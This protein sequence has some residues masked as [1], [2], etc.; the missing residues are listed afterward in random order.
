MGQLGAWLKF[1]ASSPLLTVKVKSELRSVSFI[2]VNVKKTFSFPHH[3]QCY[4]NHSWL[5][6]FGHTLFF[7]TD[8]RNDRKQRF[9]V[10]TGRIRGE[11]EGWKN[12]LVA[13]IPSCQQA[14]IN[15]AL[16]PE[17]SPDLGRSL[18]NII[19]SWK[20]ATQNLKVLGNREGVWFI[21]SFRKC[22]NM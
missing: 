1:L 7:C 8:I 11:R 19:Q 10:E 6:N 16:S 5:M 14:P 21:I 9:W 3:S 13:Y 15:V 4:I 22:V 20:F 18:Q 12:M 17:L 2:A